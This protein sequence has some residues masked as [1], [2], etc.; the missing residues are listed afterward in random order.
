MKHGMHGTPTYRSWL[1]MKARCTNRCDPFFHRYGGRGIKVH[2]PWLRS[3]ASFLRD[4]GERPAGTVLDRRKNDRHYAPGNVRWVTQK[5][6]QRNRSSNRRLTFRGQTLSLA[7]WAERV[8][9]SRFTLGTRINKLGWSV[10]RALTEK[11]R[12]TT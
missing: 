12:G 6:N 2:A 10:A 3:F 11:R 5:V 4:V 9:L 8:G 1:S 7:E